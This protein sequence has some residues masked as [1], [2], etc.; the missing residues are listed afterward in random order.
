MFGS[1]VNYE[2]ILSLTKA[3]NVSTTK[4]DQPVAVTTSIEPITANITDFTF[5]GISMSVYSTTGYFNPTY[6]TLLHNAVNTGFTHVVIS[7]IVLADLDKNTIGDWVGVTAP[8]FSMGQAITEAQSLG[9]KVF[10]KPQ[11]AAFDPYHNTN[12]NMCNPDLIVSNPSAFFIAYKS[13][14]LQ[15]AE[16]AQQYNVSILSIGNEMG[17]V[18]KPEYTYYWNDI[19]DSIR[20]VYTGKLTYSALTNTVSERWNEVNHVTFWNKLDYI[21]AGIYPNFD[22]IT[23]SDMTGT[24][25]KFN[26]GWDKLN[27]DDMM[28]KLATTYNKKVIFTETGVS[29]FTGSGGGGLTDYKIGNPNTK[30]DW[31]HQ[32]NWY[33]SFFETWSGDGKPEW[34]EGMFFWNNNPDNVGDA[35][36]LWYKNNY[37]IYGKTAEKVIASYLLPQNTPEYQSHESNYYSEVNEIDIAGFMPAFDNNFSHINDFSWA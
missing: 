9:L 33:K 35:S 3:N 2:D 30:T 34:L 1:Y 17:A 10:L 22:G 19:I 32:A 28:A 8:F 13:Y 14:I 23:D 29:S 5:K 21:G 26:E 31:D 18:T 16:L 27:Y 37:D 6:H 25:D 12:Q 24:V 11:L 36:S 15:W 4:I 20:Q 7:N